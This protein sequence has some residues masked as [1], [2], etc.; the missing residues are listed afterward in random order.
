[1]G[2]L[3]VSKMAIEDIT[4]VPQPVKGDVNGDGEVTVAD[5]NV[6][7]GIILGS[8]DNIPAADVNG[9]GEVTV[10]D[11]NAVISLIING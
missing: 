10:A 6:I 9:D 8:I 1:M 3:L 7:I 2:M 11:V 4:P 5:A